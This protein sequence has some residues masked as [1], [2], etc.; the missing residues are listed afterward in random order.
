MRQLLFTFFSLLLSADLAAQEAAPFAAVSGGKVLETLLGLALVLLLIFGLARIL[1]RIQGAPTGGSQL[2]Q[3]V[4]SMSL[5]AREKI[6]LL[7]VADKHILVA[8]TAQ[9]I[10]ALHV[11]DEALDD[12]PEAASQSSGFSTLLQSIGAGSGK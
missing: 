12:L 5:G 9:S 6:V 1:Q 10:S 8:A 3:V 7:Q 4:G 11:F 2:M